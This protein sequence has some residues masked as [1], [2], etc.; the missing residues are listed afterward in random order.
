MGLHLE[1]ASQVKQKEAP[2][3]SDQPVIHEFGG[4]RVHQIGY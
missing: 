4:L 1:S 2:I 3:L